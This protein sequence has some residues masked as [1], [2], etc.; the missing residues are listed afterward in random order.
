MNKEVSL[1]LPRHFDVK[2]VV[3]IG[4]SADYLPL[5]RYRECSFFYVIL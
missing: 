5:L 4:Y 1:L 2:Y 3:E